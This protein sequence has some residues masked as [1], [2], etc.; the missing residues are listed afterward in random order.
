M[1]NEWNFKRELA[2]KFIHFLSIFIILIY[3]FVSDIFNPKTALILLTFILIF[4]LELEYLR[5]D[6]RREIPFLKKLWSYFRREKEKDKLGGEVFFLIG[7]ILVLAV[8]DTKI[9]IAAILMTTFGDLSAALIGKRF[10]KH[11][12]SCLENRA[13]EGIIAE[14]FVNIIIGFFVFFSGVFSDFSIIGS[15]DL[16]LIVLVMSLTA[17]FV[18]SVVH[19]I[20]DNLLIP[21]FAGFNGQMVLILTK[22]V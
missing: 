16:W 6:F 8:F 5:L 22:L 10:G 11:Y 2:R 17:T 9:A 15:Y 20:D 3:F 19:K 12:L 1:T 7:A 21:L 14:F 4:F 18:E 13:W